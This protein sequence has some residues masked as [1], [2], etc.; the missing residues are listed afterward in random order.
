MP[1]SAQQ[2]DIIEKSPH[3][4]TR[5]VEAIHFIRHMDFATGNAF[6][7]IWRYG[8]KDASDIER[9]KRNYYIKNALVYRPCY[10]SE[11]VGLCMIRMLSAMAN[12]FELEQFELLIALV[13]A[14]M[15]DYELL[16][17]RARQLEL[18]PIAAEHLLL[19]GD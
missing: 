1:N 17:A 13:S 7:Y 12:E 10:V 9:G 5:S 15:G 6:K 16:I 18:F 11:D 3:Y 8:L 19:D 2:L 4:N 14:S